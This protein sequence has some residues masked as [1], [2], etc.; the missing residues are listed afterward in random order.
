MKKSPML[1]AL[2][3]LGMTAG[4]SAQGAERNEVSMAEQ[5]ASPEANA[6]FSAEHYPEQVFRLAR[7][8]HEHGRL[9]DADATFRKAIGLYRNLP[10]GEEKIPGLLTVWAGVLS[11]QPNRQVQD[12]GI[13]REV[14]LR[15]Q[16]EERA[17]HEV[18]LRKAQN[19]ANEAIAFIVGR[20]Q[21]NDQDFHQLFMCVRVFETAG[22]AQAKDQ[23]V[24]TMS[25]ILT[26]MAQEEPLSDQ[27]RISIGENFN[28]MAELYCKSP[29][30]RNLPSGPPVVV[31]ADDAPH[32]KN[33]G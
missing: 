22:N 10:G 20:P 31:C 3:A 33:R 16:S 6:G 24:T 9:R 18:E 2:L 30:G 25:N 15:I 4:A 29:Y 13:S 8:Y 26:H 5:Q 17:A 28:K 1:A 21:L 14:A 19:L 11:R 23:L 32:T 12:Y 27:A 7:I